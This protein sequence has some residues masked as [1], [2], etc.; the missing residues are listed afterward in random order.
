[1][2]SAASTLSCGTRDLSCPAAS[3]TR[4]WTCVPHIEEGF[5]TTG[6][7]GKTPRGI[8]H[9][10]QKVE[11]IWVSIDGWKHIWNSIYTHDGIVFSH[12]KECSYF[13]GC[14]MYESW[15]HQAEWNKPDRRQALFKLLWIC[16]LGLFGFAS[17][18]IFSSW[19]YLFIWISVKQT[20]HTPWAQGWLG[21]GLGV[22]GALGY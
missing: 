14:K 21:W 17:F 15:K 2:Y 20:K 22:T 8:I 9:S 5:L 10:S 16:F 7:P 6:P 12:K 19:P 4:D 3:P 11:R 1:M 18:S 13:M